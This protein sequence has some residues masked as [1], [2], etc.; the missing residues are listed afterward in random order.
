MSLVCYRCGASLSGLPMPLSRL[1]ECP[2]CTVQLHVCRMCVNFDQQRPKGCTEDDAIEVR[3][4]KSANF[5][6]YFKPRENAFTPD[7]IEADT[8]A[9]QDLA[10]LFGEASAPGD[11]STDLIRP[12]PLA[13]ARSLFED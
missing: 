7:D 12:D 10:A 11:E 9:R 13:E 3:D 4:K 6:D 8:A 1:E 5:C 2:G